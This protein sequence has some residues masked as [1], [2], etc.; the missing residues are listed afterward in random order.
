MANVG[1]H[2]FGTI[3]E[4]KQDRL[5]GYAE[6]LKGM[7]GDY[8]KQ[9]DDR[10]LALAKGLVEVADQPD[11]FQR[12]YSQLSQDDLKQIY[13][14]MPQLKY[15]AYQTPQKQLE[16]V[17]T[18]RNIETAKKPLGTSPVD[19]AIE[20][21]QQNVLLVNKD[22]PK[23][24]QDYNITD[25]VQGQPGV[26]KQNRISNGQDM[27]AA[28]AEKARLDQ[29]DFD[30]IKRAES[31]AKIADTYA[32]V[33]QRRAA[34]SKDRADAASGK[35]SSMA[36]QFFQILDGNGQ[37]VAFFNPKTNTVVNPPV[38]GR[39]SPISA[40]EREKAGNAE[41][42]IEDLTRLKELAAKNEGMIGPVAGAVTS[43][44]S[45]VFPVGE[46][47]NEIL[48]LT[49]SL[50]NRLIYLRSGKQINEQEYK[51]LAQ[52]LPRVT[53]PTQKFFVNLGR[54]E[55]E[56]NQAIS[57]NAAVNSPAPAGGSTNGGDPLGLFK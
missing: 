34:A 17:V 27:N 53:Q 55:K 52:T 14:V 21:N 44:A 33:D 24:L 30:V 8:T 43:A 5:A 37:I 54:F 3:N 4:G 16:D 6:V 32:S 18:R 51:R 28:E 13:R 2:F 57:R 23:E 39:K 22:L 36:G 15:G 41:G 12:R 49:K 31:K 26:T 1:N 56:M 7:F 42:M 50:A 20:R 9:R 19:Q 10:Y 35:G 29:L 46:D 48:Q 25:Y 40:E 47:R 38:A 11:E 45:N